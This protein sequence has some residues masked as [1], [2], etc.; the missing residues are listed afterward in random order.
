MPLSQSLINGVTAQADGPD[1]LIAWNTPAP[2]GTVFQVYVDHR[3]SWFGTSRRCHVPVPA[4]STGRNVWVDVGTVGGGE[5]HTDFSTSLASLNQG[6]AAVELSWSGGTYLDP[7]GQDD[8]QGFRIYQ[9][10]GPN[11]PVDLSAPVD[12]VPAYPGGWISDGFGLGGFG[13]GGF[14]RA[15][16]SYVWPAGS[17]ASGTWQFQVVPYDRSGTQRGPGQAVSLSVT[18]APRPPARGADGRR[19]TYTYSGPATRQVTLS[20]LASPSV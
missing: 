4:G 3:L 19:L 20:W 8:V 7:T 2:E 11:A 9:S 16:N 1:L 17:L 13:Q 12:D 14:G 15:A 10:P 18:A 6:A 5:A